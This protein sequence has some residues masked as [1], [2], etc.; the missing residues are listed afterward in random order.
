[1]NVLV[2][3]KMEELHGKKNKKSIDNNLTMKF[4]EKKLL[5]IISDEVQ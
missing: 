2:Q 5:K 4:I 1:M 3:K